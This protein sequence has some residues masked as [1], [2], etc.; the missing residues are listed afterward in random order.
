MRSVFNQGNEEINS[1]Y[2]GCQ[3]ERVGFPRPCVGPGGTRGGGLAIAQGFLDLSDGRFFELGEL[4][5]YPTIKPLE[6]QN[7]KEE[8][9]AIRHNPGHVLAVQPQD[10]KTCA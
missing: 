4:S 3:V 1:F 9:W 8:S 10:R 7:Q 6:D 2:G 5:P